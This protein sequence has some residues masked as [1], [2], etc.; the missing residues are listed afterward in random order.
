MLRPP[1]PTRPRATTACAATSILCGPFLIVVRFTSADDMH[2]DRRL[3]VSQAQSARGEQ[4]EVPRAATRGRGEGPAP[5]R[6]SAHRPRHERARRRGARS[7]GPARPAKARWSHL[8]PARRAGAPP[9]G[10]SAR[11][12]AGRGVGAEERGGGR[13][14]KAGARGRAARGNLDSR[15]RALWVRSPYYECSVW[16]YAVLPGVGISCR[17]RSHADRTSVHISLS[18]GA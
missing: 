13:K 10:Y 7:A 6:P 15:T 18:H 17:A 12:K 9:G 5:P 14:R 2:D 8:R 16:G 11:L 4:Q 1:G 3:G